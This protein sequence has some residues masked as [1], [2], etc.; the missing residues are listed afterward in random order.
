MI[1]A[2]AKQVCAEFWKEILFVIST[3]IYLFWLSK[4]NGELLA[5]FDEK[6]IVAILTYKNYSSIWFFF[7]ALALCAVGALIVIWRIKRIQF[8]FE[9][10]NDIL[11]LCLTFLAIALMIISLIEIII[12]ISVPIFQAILGA[13]I[14]IVGLS[15]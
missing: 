9:S 3:I 14:L 7:I 13:I 2:V 15:Q 4:Y 10:A 1:V 12:Y 8:L 6:D 5:L 11:M